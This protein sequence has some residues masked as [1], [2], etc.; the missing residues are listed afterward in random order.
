MD[1]GVLGH[2]RAGSPVD[3]LGRWHHLGGWPGPDEAD[4][5]HARCDPDHR[6]AGRGRDHPDPR[7]D[8]RDLPLVFAGYGVTAPELDWDDYAGLDVRGKIVVVLVNDPDFETESGKFGGKAMTYYGRWTYKYEEAA[9]RGAAGVLIV[10]ETAPAAY[11]WATVRNGR[12]GPQYD[13]VREDAAT[14]HL[15]IDE[16]WGDIDGMHSSGALVP[17]QVLLTPLRDANGLVHGV[18]AMFRRPVATL[19]P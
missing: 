14:Y 2:G 15:P 18:F 5:R 7:V 16:S 13:I 1:R 6:T 11:P 12:N 9:R 10:H 3:D 8:L 17:L 4:R 19:S